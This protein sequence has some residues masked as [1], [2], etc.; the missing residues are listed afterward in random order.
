MF[1][2]EITYFFT[3]L[4]FFTRIPCP[5]GL[6]YSS[7]I[8]QKSRKYFPL[9]G[10]I[11]GGIA[12]FIFWGA[13]NVFS[14]PVSIILSMIAS[15]LT[16]GAFHEDG[17]TD[18]CDGFGGGWGKE[19]I[20]TIMKDSRIG[21]YGTIGIILLL[22]LKFLLLY[23]IASK[24]TTWML[25]IVL[26]NAHTTSRF[27]ASMMVQTHEYVQD[28]DQSKS[29]PMASQKLSWFE[30]L[31]SFL[32]VAIPLVLFQNLWIVAVLPAT[33]L[34]KMYLG[35]YFKKHIGGYTGDCLGA[36]Q[37]VSEIVFYLAVLVLWKFM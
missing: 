13:Q 16:T 12:A 7:E 8:M 15:V 6:A 36:I 26:L 33:Y 31:Y 27:M 24:N 20:L 32:F 28:I 30:M 4:M 23:E 3:A 14:L 2:K 1:R 37:Q 10:W 25:V 22:G 11:V 35:Y 9:M 19:K 17:F 21:A 5:K 29:K 34:S 18:T